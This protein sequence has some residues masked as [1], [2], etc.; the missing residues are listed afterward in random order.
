H[1]VDAPLGHG[2]PAIA[3]ADFDAPLRRQ[4]TGIEFSNDSRLA[5]YAVTVGP[6]PLRPIV[7]ARVRPDNSQDCSQNCGDPK[8]PT[9]WQRHTIFLRTIG[10]HVRAF[11]QGSGPSCEAA[12]VNS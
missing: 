4:L 10:L 11:I 6:A 7:A 8:N 1:D 12:A 5:P 9:A 3:R 2:W